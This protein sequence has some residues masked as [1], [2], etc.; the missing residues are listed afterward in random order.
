V[1]KIYVKLPGFC[2]V[3]VYINE[4]VN[5]ETSC[6]DLNW[7]HLVENWVECYIL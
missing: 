7:I 2:Y 5:K 1:S 4:N 3:T 6:K